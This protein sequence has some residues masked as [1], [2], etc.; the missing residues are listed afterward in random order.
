MSEN[1]KRI[2]PSG[3]RSDSKFGIHIV[4]DEKQMGKSIILLNQTLK[5]VSKRV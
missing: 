2:T 5:T 3:K 4:L 1:K